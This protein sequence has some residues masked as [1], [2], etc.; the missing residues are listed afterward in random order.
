MTPTQLSR[1]FMGGLVNQPL[2]WVCGGE[3]HRLDV[4]C[5]VDD[6]VEQVGADDVT[7]ITLPLL[8]SLL[9]TAVDRSI[10]AVDE[11]QLRE[12]ELGAI[13]AQMLIEIEDLLRREATSGTTLIS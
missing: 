7:E 5:L 12:V 8:T 9:Q 4:K 11:T 1:F 13:A 3:F 6:M 2:Y 10:Y